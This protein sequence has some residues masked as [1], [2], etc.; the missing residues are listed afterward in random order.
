M[1]EPLVPPPSIARPRIRLGAIFALALA[2]GLTAW[3]LVDR[4]DPGDTS[5][6]VS[7]QSDGPRVATPAGLSSLA[8]FR[9]S[10]VYWVGRRAGTVYEVTETAEGY[11]YVRYLPSG[12][13]IGDPRAA[14]LT[15]ATYPRTDAYAD[16]EAASRRP[17]AAT[18]RLPDGGLAVY[19]KGKPTNI[20]LAHRG[21]GEQIEVYDPSGEAARR[22][23]R[24]GLVRP[25]P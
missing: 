21:S 3:I 5:L 6:R 14:F 15:V 10:P 17:G 2:A 9:G 22:L 23:V 1:D 8:A 19:D 16:V 24:A 20:Y 12:T 18:I 7:A 11:V 25:V 4:D 13:A